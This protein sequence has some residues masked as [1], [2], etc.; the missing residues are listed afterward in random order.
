[1]S[2]DWSSDVCS[3]DLFYVEIN[4]RVEA[5]RAGRKQLDFR[6]LNAVRLV[7]PSCSKLRQEVEL[8]VLIRRVVVELVK[9]GFMEVCEILRCAQIGRAPCRERVLLV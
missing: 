3:S 1:I 5:H 2:R 8:V 7:L 4:E 6:E 9:A